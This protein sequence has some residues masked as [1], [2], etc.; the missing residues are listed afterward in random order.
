MEKII[1]D[2][3]KLNRIQTGLC[4]V[5][6]NVTVVGK[7]CECENLPVIQIKM[8]PPARICYV[9]QKSITDFA[10]LSLILKPTEG[11]RTLCLKLK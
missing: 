2:L 8:A 6:S 10:N 4:I 7:N 9:M 11:W 5:F 1:P 3:R